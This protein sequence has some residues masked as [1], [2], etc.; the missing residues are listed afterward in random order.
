MHRSVRA[1]ARPPPPRTRRTVARV[2]RNRPPD[3]RNH[4]RRPRQPH[5]RPPLRPSRQPR[6]RTTPRTHT[7]LDRPPDRSATSRTL[8]LVLTDSRILGTTSPTATASRTAVRNAD[9]S[10]TPVPGVLS[11]SRTPHRWGHPFRCTDRV[12]LSPHGGAR[13]PGRPTLSRRSPPGTLRAV[14]VRRPVPQAE[15]NDGLHTPPARGL[16]PTVTTPLSASTRP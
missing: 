3:E 4:L 11:S 12:D 1:G 7:P 9:T 5:H 10:E 13:P 2:G 14:H 6:P 16:C 8:A 15:R